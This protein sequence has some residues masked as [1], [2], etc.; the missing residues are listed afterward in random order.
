VKRFATTSSG[1]ILTC[2]PTFP[3]NSPVRESQAAS[4]ATVPSFQYVPRW[5]W[6]VM[7]PL[8]PP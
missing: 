4:K 8:L 2:L 7:L 3:R 1:T 5:Q 6:L